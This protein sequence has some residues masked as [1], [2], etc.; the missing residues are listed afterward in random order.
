MCQ[1][2]GIV[3]FCR[4]SKVSAGCVNAVW[5]GSSHKNATLALW[6][7]CFSHAPQLHP[8]IHPSIQL[9]SLSPPPSLSW[10]T[11]MTPNTAKRFLFKQSSWVGGCWLIMEQKINLSVTDGLVCLENCNTCLESLLG[12]GSPY[13]ALGGL[14]VLTSQEETADADGRAQEELRILLIMKLTQCFSSNP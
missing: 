1:L 4:R 12:T 7:Y 11:T 5:T 14:Q 3:S 13:W 2:W 9:F 6:L 8:S 10:A